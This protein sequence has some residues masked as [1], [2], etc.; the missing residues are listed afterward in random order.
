M[1]ME[2]EAVGRQKNAAPQASSEIAEDDT[3]ETYEPSD[4]ERNVAAIDA[5]DH[6]GVIQGKDHGFTATSAS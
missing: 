2:D 4:F 6:R 1:E 5:A 3:R